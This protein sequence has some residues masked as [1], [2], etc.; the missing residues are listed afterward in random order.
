[1]V[2][3]VTMSNT[4]M[5][6]PPMVTKLALTLSRMPTDRGV[7][8]AIRMMRFWITALAANEAIR[9]V[10]MLALR[11]GRNAARSTNRA[12]S[13]APASA[14]GIIS[15]VEWTPKRRIAYP[16]QV[17]KSPWAKFTIRMTPKM[18]AMATA[19]SA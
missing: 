8:P 6:T 3:V 12:T 11:T 14:T 5:R 16:A 18:S 1:M 17:M 9:R 4:A 10:G 7:D 2:T 19:D 15:Q 13:T